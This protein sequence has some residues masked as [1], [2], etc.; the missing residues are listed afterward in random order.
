[1]EETNTFQ[2]KD[3]SETSDI[4]KRI[5]NCSSNL[6]VYLIQCKSCSK[7]YLGST[8]TPLCTRFNN[9]KS[10]ARKVSNLFQ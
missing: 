4:R 6:I 7:H 3:K 10:R 1:M 2:I 5:L 8:I 9:Y